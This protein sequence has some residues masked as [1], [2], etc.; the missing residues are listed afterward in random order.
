MSDLS[1]S[2]SK[3]ASR[4]FTHLSDLSEMSGEPKINGLQIFPEMSE[5]SKTTKHKL[6]SGHLG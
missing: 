2:L 5:M 6:S 1:R 3:A 4:T